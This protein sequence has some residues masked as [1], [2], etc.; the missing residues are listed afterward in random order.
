MLL[1]S[2]VIEVH[3]SEPKPLL[4]AV[5]SPGSFP[6]LYFDL[7]SQTY[8]GLVPDFFADLEQQGILKAEF[9]DSN[10]LRSEQSIIEGNVDLYL[11]NR[12]WLK[13]PEKV[14]TSIPIVD[15]LT[16]LYSLSP[17]PEDFLP[18]TL[19]N[20]QVC[21]QQDFV[22]TGLQQSFKNKKLLRLDSSSQNSMGSMLAKGRC[23]YAILNNYNAKKTFYEAEYC[24]LDI[25]QSPQ[26]TS[27]IELTIVMRPELHHVKNI[28]DKQLEAFISRG[29]VNTSLLA[30]STKPNFPKPVTCKN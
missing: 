30:H 25:Y 3:G 6:Y 21:T 10:Q 2:N 20:K 19:V 1:V 24:H 26:P 18:G 29:K 15:H 13:Q 23:D 16:Y 4:F 7:S 28:I 11:A 17:F 8:K 14:I 12:E 9:I 27:E 22:Y 5:N